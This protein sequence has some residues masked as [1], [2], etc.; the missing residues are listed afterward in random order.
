MR[1]SKRMLSS[2]KGFILI[3][4]I[5]A[6]IILFALTFLVLNLST[7][8]LKVSAQ[9]VGQKKASS[10]AETGIHRM[11][12]NFDPDP[13][14]FSNTGKYNTQFQVDASNDPASVYTIS[15]PT[16]PTTGP[17]FLPLTGYS[18]GGG[19]QWGQKR[20]LVNVEGRNTAYNTNASIH[21]GVG[22][23]PVEISTMMR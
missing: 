22:Y 20:F 1:Y 17:A 5:M 16:M 23:G 9:N 19:Q 11:I 15:T 21:A 18:I 2:E 14:D 12:Q 3:T 6:C 7:S 10:S 4:A 8:D 13:A